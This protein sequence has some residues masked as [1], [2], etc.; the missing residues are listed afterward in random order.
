M[1]PRPK[2]LMGGSRLKRQSIFKCSWMHNDR[3]GDLK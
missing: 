1:M 3:T 2:R